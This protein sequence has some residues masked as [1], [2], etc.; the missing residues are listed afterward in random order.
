[1]SFFENGFTDTQQSG[2]ET[3][4]FAGDADTDGETPDV[5][6][7]ALPDGDNGADNAGYDYED[8]EEPEE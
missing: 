7:G 3:G 6:Q 5:D 8:P 1:M 2:T 4:D